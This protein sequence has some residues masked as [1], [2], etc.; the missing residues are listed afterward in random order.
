MS[1][2][3]EVPGEK[4]PSVEPCKCNKQCGSELKKTETKLSKR[5]KQFLK[6]SWA[7][8]SKVTVEPFVICYM[9]PSVLAGLAVQNLCLEKSCLVNLQ[10]DEQTCTHIMQGRTHNYSEQ[11]KNVQTMVASMTA[12]SFPLQT[13]MSGIITLFLG[14]WSDRIG[15]RKTFMVLPIL[16]KLISTIGL[17]LSTVFF[18]QVGMNETALIDGL[19]PALAGG[20]VAMTMIVYSYITDITTDSERTF[21][22]GIITAIL[23]LSR[24][25]GKALSGITAREF[26]YYG[27]FMIA[28][29]F[30]LFG[31]VYI[32]LKLKEKPKKTKEVESDKTPSILSVLSVKDFVATVNVAFKVREG[33]RRVQIILIMCAYMFIVGP[34]LGEVQ[35]TYWFTRYKFKF[36][37][38]DYSLYLTY[39]A[40]VDSVGSFITIY[41]FCK[42]WN[43]DDS[44]IGVIACLSRIAASVLYA[45]APNRTIYFLGPVLDM[46]SSAG[47]TSLRS[48]ATKLVNADE[49]GKTS[50]LISISEAL[51]PV[52]YSPIYSKVYLL[53]LSTMPGAFYFISALLAIP[54]IAIYL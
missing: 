35:M 51:I 26:G 29:V 11:E 20:R 52:I 42:R 32:I 38:V 16:G 5:L 28:C 14:A 31:F 47:A 6:E 45:M 25:I 7:F 10:Y 19:P 53:T 41:L 36:T 33:S 27:V 23:N 3:V 40:L 44:I 18:L 4:I 24:P 9:L 22:L 15:N 2:P 37:E 49:V 46:F 21:R 50:S 39:S 48:I 17:I 8:R 13:A 43:M 30:Y 54:A 34:V 1:L 12:W